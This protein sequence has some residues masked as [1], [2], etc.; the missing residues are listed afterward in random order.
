MTEKQKTI[1]LS[2]IGLDS[3]GLV[4]KITNKVF[5]SGGN[6]IDVEENCR[7]GLFSIFLTIAFPSTGDSIDSIMASLKSIQDETG[8]KVILGE[9]YER[10]VNGS[11]E[12]ENH[13]VTILGMDRPGLIARISGFFLKHN[14]NIENCRMIARGE[15]FSMEMLIDSMGMT[16]GR[17]LDRNEAIDHWKNELKDLCAGLDQSVVIQSE[18]IFNKIKKLV[19]FDLESTLLEDFSI[20]DFLETIKG[21]ILSIDNTTRF[22]EDDKGRM[23]AVV[24]NARMLKNIPVRDLERLSAILRLTPGSTELIKVLKSMGFKIAILSSGFDLFVK[25][26]L[27]EAGVDYA[28]SNTL[29]VDE[30]DIVTGELEEP[31][32]T[33]GTKEEILEFIMNVEKISRDQV[34]AIGDGSTRSHFIKNAGLSIAFKPGEKSIKTDGVLSSDQIINLL[35]CLGIPKKELNRYLEG[36]FAEN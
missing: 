31:V 17:Y 22:L 23:E 4:S 30:N 5:E 9:Y 19:V 32:I 20:K 27:Q 16:T 2:A 12:K 21:E 24:G 1:N 25:K 29:Q 10:G 8:L 13:L 28:F 33:D 26:I 15:F 7:R 14:I 34:I 18:N 11:A 3:P 6:I 35:Y 36:S